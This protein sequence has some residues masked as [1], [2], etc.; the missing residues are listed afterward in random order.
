[1]RDKEMDLLVVTPN[2]SHPHIPWH[3]VGVWGN[4]YWCRL[5]GWLPG[6]HH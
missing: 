2:C 6:L 1:M 5:R 3:W 4:S